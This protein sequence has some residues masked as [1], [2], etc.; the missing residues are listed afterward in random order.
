MAPIMLYAEFGPPDGNPIPFA[1]GL[2]EVADVLL[3]VLLVMAGTAACRRRPLVALRATR[4]LLWCVLFLGALQNGTGILRVLETPM[5][6]LAAVHRLCAHGLVVL[7][8]LVLPFSIGVL[9]QRAI[10][11][12]RWLAGLAIPGLLGSGIMG[13]WPHSPATWARRNRRY[14]ARHWCGSGY[15]IQSCSPWE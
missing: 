9:L 1:A 12:R 7:L 10:A 2:T 3:P 6:E 8:W 4:Y 14:P 5:A 15:C 11:T 13:C